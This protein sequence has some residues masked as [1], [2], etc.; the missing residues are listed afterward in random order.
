MK[1]PDWVTEN[2][3]AETYYKRFLT[4]AQLNIEEVTTHSSS[5]NFDE[6]KD[7]VGEFSFSSHS[8]NRILNRFTALTVQYI[9]ICLI[10]QRNCSH[11]FSFNTN[12]SC[13]LYICICIV[14]FQFQINRLSSHFTRLFLF[15]S[16]S[17]F[18]EMLLDS[19]PEPGT[20]QM[21]PALLTEFHEVTKNQVM[22]WNGGNQNENSDYKLLT[23]FVRNNWTSDTDTYYY[24]LFA[25]NLHR[26]P[27]D[28]NIRFPVYTNYMFKYRIFF[29]IWNILWIN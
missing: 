17:V 23:M 9:P 4:K 5:L 28:I 6:L 16:I 21:P 10:S 1:I 18:V 15:F 25:R 20:E 14:D 8:I 2:A 11:N 19:N 27:F 12:M 13:T 24:F 3:S 7:A 29:W 26:F 22:K